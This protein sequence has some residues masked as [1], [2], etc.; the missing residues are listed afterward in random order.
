MSGHDS[1]HDKGHANSGNHNSG[2]HG[3]HG[4][5]NLFATLLGK[6]GN[7]HGNNHGNHNGNHGNAHG[8]THGN[9][10]HG[11]GHGAHGGHEEHSREP[12]DIPKLKEPPSYENRMGGLY[13]ARIKYKGLYDLDGLYRLM[14][15]WF[16]QRRY[17]LY[18]T[19]YKARPPELEIRWTAEREKTGFVKEIITIYYHS[20]GEYDID[21]VIDGKKK[22]MTNARLILLIDGDIEAPYNDIYGRPRWTANSM[23]RR[24]LNLF[25]NWFAK[26][27][28]ESVHW[29]TL[30]YEMWKLHG[31][32]KT[33][34]GMEAK[35][36][37]Y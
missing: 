20:Y 4:S 17:R 21:V 16:R 30:Y 34:L 19:L 10:N 14:A 35:G 23:E 7:G 2:N 6:S 27:E 13:P 22:K 24:L 25:Q 31:E 9:E 28:L 12:I 26:R 3:S 8:N 1:G 18:E 36:N 11:N 37:V 32:I 33:F 29:D 5:G 15:N